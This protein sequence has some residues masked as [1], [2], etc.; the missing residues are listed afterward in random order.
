MTWDDH[1]R[2]DLLRLTMSQLAGSR[3]AT[4]GIARGGWVILVPLTPKLILPLTLP[5]QG[6]AHHVVLLIMVP[7]LLDPT[8][9]QMVSANSMYAPHACTTSVFSYLIRR[10][11]ASPR[12]TRP[13]GL[14]ETPSRGLGSKPPFTSPNSLPCPRLFFLLTKPLLIPVSIRA[15]IQRFCLMTIQI[16]VLL[17]AQVTMITLIFLLSRVSI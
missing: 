15:T 5:Q 4:A 7:V 9:C 3:E 13:G 14:P 1:Y 2:I 6:L 16:R 8:T 11:S 12:S 10:R 17:L